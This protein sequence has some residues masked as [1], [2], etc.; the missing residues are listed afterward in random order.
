[1][2]THE[3]TEPLGE[4]IDSSPV[5]RSG[6]GKSAVPRMALALGL[7]VAAQFVLQLDVSIVNVFGGRVG[8]LAA[9]GP[10]LLV[11]LGAFAVASVAR[12]SPASLTLAVAHRRQL[13]IMTQ[14]P[15]DV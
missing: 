13:A 7:V 14:E 12:L 3:S 5:S 1:M 10:A 9:H 8:D 11:G 2:K 6:S 4:V 15:V